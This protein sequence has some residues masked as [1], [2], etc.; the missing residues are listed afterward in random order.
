MA[1]AKPRLLEFF[2]INV[3]K[4]LEGKKLAELAGVSEWARMIRSLKQEGYDIECIK[5]GEHS[6]SYIMRSLNKAEGKKRGVINQ[7]MHYRISQRDNSICQRCGR[8]IADKVILHIDHKIPVEWGGKTTDENLWVLC[9]DCNLGK[10]HWLS[11]SNTEEMKL[12]FSLESAESRLKKYFE[13]HPNEMIDVMQL[14]LVG[15][16][17]EWT[18]TVRFL[19]EKFKMKIQPV[20][21]NKL[22]GDAYIY[23]K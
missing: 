17:R 23:V 7:K 10:K 11:D 13:L 12:I 4:Y 19:R 6:G 8:G 1:G 21:K 18:R 2:Q 14:H 3:G 20:R 22:H 5:S 15:G 16:I 9:S